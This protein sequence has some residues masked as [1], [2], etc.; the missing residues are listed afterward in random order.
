M[1]HSDTP[2]AGL[3]GLVLDDELLIALDIQQILEA[4]GAASVVCAGNAADALAALRDTPNFD[5]AVIDVILNG[6]TGTSIAV[7]AALIEQGTPFVFLTG[8]RAEDVRHTARFPAAP[9]VEKP[10]EA[11]RLLE[12]LRRAL[13]GS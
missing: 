4:A 12:A 3:R 11:A 8:M 6:A 5:F 7:V 1:V 2:L 13:T 9:V 10:Y